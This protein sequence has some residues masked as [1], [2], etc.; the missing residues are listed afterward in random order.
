[1]TQA[2][3][4]LTDQSDNGGVVTEKTGDPLATGAC[5]II[6]RIVTDYQKSFGRHFDSL[7]FMTSGGN[8]IQ[9]ASL[10]SAKS[11][12]EIWSRLEW[13]ICR[14]QRRRQDWCDEQFVLTGN[15]GRPASGVRYRVRVGPNVVASGVTDSG[16]RTVRINTGDTR[17]LT[18]EI[19]GDI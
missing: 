1:M 6:F 18:F 8:F 12:C 5:A 11:G 14:C 3:V 15:D 13:D 19:S 9:G 10:R 17:R 7:P 2:V 16:G 4:K